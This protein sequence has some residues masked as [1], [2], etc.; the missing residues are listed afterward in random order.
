MLIIININ[1]LKNLS[2]TVYTCWVPIAGSEKN[3]QTASV[4][5]F[6]MLIAP[7]WQNGWQRSFYLRLLSF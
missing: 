1:Q 5:I 7:F 4:L 3:L 6:Y 2:K